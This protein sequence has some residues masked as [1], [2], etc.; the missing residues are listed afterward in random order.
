MLDHANDELMAARDAQRDIAAV[1]YVRTRQIRHCSHCVENFFR[2]CASYRCHRSDKNTLG[3]RSDRFRHPS[4][5]YA[6]GLRGDG[7]RLLSQKCEFAAEFVE[8]GDESLR[9]GRVCRTNFVRRPECFE[10]DIDGAIVEMHP[11]PVW[12]NSNDGEFSH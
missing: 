8:Y 1:V 12:Q 10:D 9:C 4:S 11:S 7:P 6:I 3:I 2:H 5:Y